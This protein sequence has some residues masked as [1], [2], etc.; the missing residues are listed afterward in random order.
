MANAELDPTCKMPF[1]SFQEHQKESENPAESKKKKKKKKRSK[2]IP[3]LDFVF[4]TYLCMTF[5]C[6]IFSDHC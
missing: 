3:R 1:Q 4:Q 6:T 5:I 2:G